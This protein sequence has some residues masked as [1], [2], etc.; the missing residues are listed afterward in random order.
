[1][2]VGDVSHTGW[3]SNRT[4]TPLWTYMWVG[5]WMR[6]RYLVH[7][8]TA[9]NSKMIEVYVKCLFH[10]FPSV[11]GVYNLY[12]SSIEATRS[13]FSPDAV[14]LSTAISSLP[15]HH[16]ATA[17]ELF[18]AVEA[19]AGPGWTRWRA[20]AMGH[21]WWVKRCYTKNYGKSPFSMG[22]STFSTGP[23]SIAILT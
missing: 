19:K 8:C 10:I 7:P 1:M 15:A 11:S 21:H 13:P 4:A 3:S 18:E 6:T 16:W 22:K 5:N 17:L 14:G 23:F 2:L 20:M 9:L 12:P